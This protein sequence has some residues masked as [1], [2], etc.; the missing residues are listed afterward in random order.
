M[1]DER[2]YLMTGKTHLAIGTAA[3]VCLLHPASPREWVVST[4]A[5]A[6]GSVI[7]DVDV[8]TSN[9][10]EKLNQISALT[11]LAAAAV[12]FLEFRFHL[13][14][15]RHFSRESSWF[16]L[17][18]GFLILLAVCTFGKS[19]PHRSFMHSIPCWLLLS[20]VVFY[21]YPA[22]MPGFSVGM[23]SHIAADLLNRKKVRLLYP[24]K[25]GLCFDLCSSYGFISRILTRAAGAIF[26]AVSL[27][28]FLLYFLSATGRI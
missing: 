3:A 24:L 4:A 26:I 12:C 20:G 2:T 9:S 11:V 22:L 25:W 10:H 6:V 15:L 18:S 1:T 17:F 5:A 19:R 28:L 8:S 7:C 23:L 27:I 13:G 14:I 16:R 21:M